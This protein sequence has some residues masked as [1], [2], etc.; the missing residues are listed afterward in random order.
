[1]AQLV[2]RVGRG[3]AGASRRRFYIIDVSAGVQNQGRQYRQENGL[4]HVSLEGMVA[5]QT[6]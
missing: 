1:M 5:H 6:T 3:Y 4:H 2:I